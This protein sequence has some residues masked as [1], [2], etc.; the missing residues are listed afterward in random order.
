MPKLFCVSDIHGYYDELRTAL[1]SA[2]FDPENREHWLIGCGDYFDRGKKP[3]QVM[4]Y[5]Q[6]LPRKV[7][8]RGNHEDLFDHL[9]KRGYPQSHDYHNGTFKTVLDLS[10][11]A[12]DRHE[13]FACASAATRDFF[14]QMVPYFETEHYVFVHG[15]FPIHGFDERLPTYRQD[16]RH[17]SSDDWEQARWFNAMQIVRYG[18]KEQ[19]KTIV[20]GHWHCSWG[21]AIKDGTPEFGYGANFA[22][23]YM[24]G[25]IAID[26]CTTSSRMVNVLVLEDK[27]IG[28]DL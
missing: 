9:C 27:F 22:P 6:S 15:F 10:G 17:A 8:V 23:F 5:L 2:G 19:G 16:W 11:D 20:A 12:F 3:L 25:L 13:A 14:S 24:D 1:D 21:H 18:I 7:L 28:E 26:A 4:Q